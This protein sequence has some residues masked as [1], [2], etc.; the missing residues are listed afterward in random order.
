M[1]SRRLRRRRSWAQLAAVGSLLV[2]APLTAAASPEVVA[3]R[4]V[5]SSLSEEF[6]PAVPLAPLP[7]VVAVPNGNGADFYDLS[8]AQAARLGSFRTAGAVTRASAAGTTVFLF[9][10]AR[11]VVAVDASDPAAP[12]A[13]GSIGNLGP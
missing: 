2:G 7:G 3:V 5:T 10:G 1:N 6:G 8:G 13:S 11:G 12:Q 9:A 4:G